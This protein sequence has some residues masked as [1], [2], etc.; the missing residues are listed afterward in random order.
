VLRIRRGNLMSIV[1]K[2]AEIRRPCDGGPVPFHRRAFFAGALWRKKEVHEDFEPPI[3]ENRYCMGSGSSA[4]TITGGASARV[5]VG[6]GRAYGPFGNRGRFPHAGR[7]KAGTA[8]GTQSLGSFPEPRPR[9][10][11]DEG[12]A[13]NR[14]EAARSVAL[15]EGGPHCGGQRSPPGKGRRSEPPGTVRARFQ[16]IGGLGAEHRVHRYSV[17]RNREL[18]GVVVWFLPINDS[19]GPPEALD[20]EA[21]SPPSGT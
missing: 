1:I 5:F 21:R 12:A 16:R 6:D 19:P 14:G 15:R 13:Q 4:R 18:R 20:H 7:S 17:D 11:Y 8:V 2:P 9:P 10:Q 3:G